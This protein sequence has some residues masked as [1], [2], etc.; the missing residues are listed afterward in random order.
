MRRQQQ[1]RAA[2][3]RA[4]VRDLAATGGLRQRRVL[5]QDD[6]LVR[7]NQAVLHA[8]VRDAPASKTLTPTRIKLLLRV[9]DTA[10]CSW[11]RGAPWPGRL[12]PIVRHTH[13]L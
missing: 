13:I 3:L 1:A 10:A 9:A 4:L 8:A 6:S 12:Q 2:C 5:E 11:S 7:T